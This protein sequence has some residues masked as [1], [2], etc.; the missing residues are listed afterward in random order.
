MFEDLPDNTVSVEAQN[1]PNLAF[2]ATPILGNTWF[3]LQVPGKEEVKSG[4]PTM[5]YVS[6]E[7]ILYFS[8]MMNPLS[9]AFNLTGGSNNGQTVIGGQITQQDATNTARV[10]QGTFLSQGG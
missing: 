2:Y 4:A 5:P 8:Q 1:A 9:A 10:A 3:N 6:P 7:S